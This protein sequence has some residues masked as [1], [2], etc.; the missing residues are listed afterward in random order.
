MAEIDRESDDGSPMGEDRLQ[1]HLCQAAMAALPR[2]R[3]GYTIDLA[4]GDAVLGTLT[5]LEKL[6]LPT[7]F[8]AWCVTNAGVLSRMRDGTMVPVPEDTLQDVAD[9]VTDAA[10]TLR[11]MDCEPLHGRDARIAGV[12][13]GW[14]GA[15]SQYEFERLEQRADEVAGALKSLGFPLT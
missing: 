1:E 4:T 13:D 12:E 3:T 10:G 7:N 2:D 14:S 8:L 6:G 11:R 9:F 15:P 5:A